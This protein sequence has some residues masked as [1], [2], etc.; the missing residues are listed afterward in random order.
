M[1]NTEEHIEPSDDE[2]TISIGHGES[3]KIKGEQK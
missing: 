1:E 3:E 2:I